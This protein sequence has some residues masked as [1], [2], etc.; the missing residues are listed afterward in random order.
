MYVKI[1]LFNKE[2]IDQ[3]M[4]NKPYTRWAQL[5]KYGILW[6]LLDNP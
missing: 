1:V 5:N 6:F 4:P 3:N 2:L